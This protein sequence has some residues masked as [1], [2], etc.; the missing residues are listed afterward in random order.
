MKSLF[1]GK[2]IGECRVRST[3]RN[4]ADLDRGFSSSSLSVGF[5][6]CAT[7]IKE[8]GKLPVGDR[9]SVLR[10]FSYNV[11]FF[12]KA[13]IRDNLGGTTQF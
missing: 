11:N 13:H 2:F 6:S 9:R 12:E 1:I 5:K 7:N 8:A 4:F 3:Q 10:G